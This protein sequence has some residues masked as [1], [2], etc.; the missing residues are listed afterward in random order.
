MVKAVAAL[1]TLIKIKV[2]AKP[3]TRLTKINRNSNRNGFQKRKL[4][5]INLKVSNLIKKQNTK[6]LSKIIFRRR[7][8]NLITKNKISINLSS[9]INMNIQ[10]TMKIKTIKKSIHK[11]KADLITKEVGVEEEA[12]VKEEEQIL[13]MKKRI[14]I[15]PIPLISLTREKQKIKCLIQVYKVL[16]N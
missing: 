8:N 14:N 10:T 7:K 9:K 1:I 15:N 16:N 13:S 3:L 12:E 2:L 11:I 4:K 6:S 5:K